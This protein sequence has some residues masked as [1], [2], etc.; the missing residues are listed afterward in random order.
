MNLKQKIKQIKYIKTT[1]VL[2]TERL[3]LRPITPKDADTAFVWLSDEKVNRFMPYNLYKNKGLPPGPL[4]S[5]T[6]E[7]I[8][9][10]ILPEKGQYLYF[11][12]QKSGKVF[13]AV[14]SEEHAENVALQR[15]EEY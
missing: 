13:F 15:R 10:A 8:L 4:C 7:A 12:T 14:T 5:P 1:P 9:C 3:I 11:V 6:R 2:E